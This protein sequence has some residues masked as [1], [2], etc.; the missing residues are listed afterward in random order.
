MLVENRMERLCAKFK[1][2]L[3][4]LSCVRFF[5][6]FKY[7]YKKIE[8]K[9]MRCNMNIAHVCHKNMANK[10][11]YWTNKIEKET[12]WKREKRNFIGKIL[13]C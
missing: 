4:W 5:S 1:L 8:G 3:L 6:I 2:L 11:K 7:I 10:E 13:H 9:Y 12:E